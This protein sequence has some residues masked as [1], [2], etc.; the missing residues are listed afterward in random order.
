MPIIKPASALR[1]DYVGI[2]KLARE[3]KQPVFLTK[4]GT[5]DMVLI[6]IEEYD[7]KIAKLE[8]YEMLAEGEADIEAGRV[9]SIEQVSRDMLDTISKYS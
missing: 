8:L 1:N 2:A 7:I 6:P 3:T 4:N 5:G 9:V